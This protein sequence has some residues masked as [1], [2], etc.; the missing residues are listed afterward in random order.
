MLSQAPP[1]A[2]SFIF[3]AFIFFASPDATSRQRRHADVF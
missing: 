3:L 1:H 2:V